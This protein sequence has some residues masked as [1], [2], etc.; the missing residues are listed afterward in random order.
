LPLTEWDEF[1]DYDWQAIYDSM[2]KPALFFDGRNV[3]RRCFKSNWVRLSQQVRNITT[4]SKE[5]ITISYKFISIKK[6]R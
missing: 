5:I 3:R 2:Q 1:T 6:S 4:S